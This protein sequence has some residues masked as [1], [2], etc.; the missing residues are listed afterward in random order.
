MALNLLPN[1]HLEEMATVL[2]STGRYRVLRRL[3]PRLEFEKPA[4]LEV[5]RAVFVDVETT[6]LDPSDDEIIEIA[7]IPFDFSSDGRIFAVHEPFSRFRDPGRAV[8]AAVTAL[9]GITDEMVH[10]QTIDPAEVAA[11]LGPAVLVIAHNAGFDRRFLERFCGAF[12]HLAWAC[13]WLEIDWKAEGFDGSKLI[14]L[15]TGFGLFFDGHRAVADCHAGIEILARTLPRSGRRALDALLVSARTPR[16]RIWALQ[17]PFEL[18]DHLK[19]RGYH[20]DNGSTGRIR[21]WYVDVMDDE[22]SV[23]LTFLRTEIYGRDDVPIER[24]RID[25][26]DRYSG[27]Y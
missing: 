14:Q 15:A 27:R 25:A 18:K 3:V 17:A 7:M 21:A 13:S 26:F 5:R 20:W 12:V 2:E 9:T 24:R 8:P 16:W 10:G 22:L 23:E 19:K 6:G 4:G 11:F 1:A